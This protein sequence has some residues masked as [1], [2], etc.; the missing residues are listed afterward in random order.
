MQCEK[1]TSNKGKRIHLGTKQDSRQDI[2]NTDKRDSNIRGSPLPGVTSTKPANI[3]L[4]TFQKDY[5]L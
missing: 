5:N 3:L 1:Y 4:V 2:L